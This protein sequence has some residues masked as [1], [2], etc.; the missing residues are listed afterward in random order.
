MSHSGFRSAGWRH[1]ICALAGMVILSAAVAIFLLF[2]SNA[3]GRT[4]PPVSNVSAPSPEPA[5][6]ASFAVFKPPVGTAA[7]I[8]GTPVIAEWTRTAKPGAVLA[9]TGSRLSSFSGSNAGED[10]EFQVFSQGADG[11][12]SGK[13]SLLKLDGLKAAVSLPENL[14]ANQEYLIWPVNS[15][16]AGSPIA[17]NATEAWWIGPDAATRGDTV[18]VYGRNLAH[19]DARMTSNI[20]IQKT[21]AR[22][23]WAAVSAANPYKVDFTVPAGLADGIYDVWIHNGLGGHYGWS[24]PLALTINAGMPW[25]AQTFNVKQYGAQGDGVTD[26]EAAIEAAVQAAGQNPW[27]TLY[28]PTGT[29]MVS[30]GFYLPSKVRWLGDGATKTYLKANADFVKPA[31]YDS[32]RYCLIYGMGGTNNVTI[33]G[34]TID[35]NGN[36]NGYLTTPVYMRG[37]TDVRFLNATIN[38]K[39]YNTADFHASY[40]VAFRNCAIIGGGNGIFF[41]SARQVSIDGCQ[42][43]GTNDVNTMLTFWGA[44]SMSCTNTTGQDYDETQPDGFAQGRFFYGSTQWGSNRN[45][46]VGDC[47]TRSLA[48]RPSYSNQ[49]SG[50]QLLWENG[51]H[52]SGVPTSATGNTV[53]FGNAAFFQDPGLTAGQYD[54]VIVNGMGLGQ[55]RKIVGCSESTI[56]VS[57]AWNVTPDNS[58]TVIIAGVV[59]HCAIYHNSL[60]GKSDYATRDT[61]S[62][63]VQPYGNSYDFVVDDNTIS[64]VRNGVYMWGM[65]EDSLT[66]KSVTSVYF[67]YVANNTVQ[68]CVNGIVGVS[69]AWEGW[70]AADPPV[71]VS[72]LANTVVGN[73]IT[74]MTGAGV[75]ELAQTPPAGDAVDLVVFDRNVVSKTPITMEFEP[76]NRVNNPIIYKNELEIGSGSSTRTTK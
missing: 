2:I 69:E 53:T 37:N 8:A 40:R 36:M 26:D 1:F 61:A 54:A 64:Q 22:G 65:A 33:Q 72:Y 56:T 51:T 55:H 42:V 49:N 17:V 31:S 38:A 3:A 43:Y 41:G 11:A 27:S 35:A 32:R 50:E 6:P 4:Y 67:N 46:Y 48:V 20:Y 29:Y 25:T 16:G 5:L 57:P 12:V 34:L 75:A 10:T 58:S 7:P 15:L 70:P 30:R 76:A 73:R 19:L 28:F 74:S 45:I 23:V 62:A 13:T 9:L 18:S 71:G 59:S 68:N 14:P 24:G 66:P 39:G 44:D 21:G 52:F 63:G 60:Q 47:T